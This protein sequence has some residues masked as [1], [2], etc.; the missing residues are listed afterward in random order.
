[1]GGGGG[2]HAQLWLWPGSN[3]NTGAVKAPLDESRG[4]VSGRNAGLGLKVQGYVLLLM[5]STHWAS[6]PLRA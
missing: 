2:G 3:Q 1:M 5:T 6:L 4:A